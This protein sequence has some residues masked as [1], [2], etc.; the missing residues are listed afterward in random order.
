LPGLL[1]YRSLSI[2]AGYKGLKYTVAGGGGSPQKQHLVEGAVC[3]SSGVLV[4]R[5][6][7]VANRLPKKSHQHR[8][9][10]LLRV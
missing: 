7:N 6:N 2:E 1:G 5:M 10:R 9:I 8:K 4:Q 3:G